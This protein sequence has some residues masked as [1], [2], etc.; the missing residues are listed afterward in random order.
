[1]PNSTRASNA[2]RR[3]LAEDLE[4]AA[5]R[6]QSK[7]AAQAAANVQ[8]AAN[9][10]N[11]V[12]LRL[13]ADIDPT[14]TGQR[15]TITPAIVEQQIDLL[16]NYTAGDAFLYRQT[17]RSTVSREMYLNSRLHRASAADLHRRGVAAGAAHHRAGGRG[18]DGRGTNRRRQA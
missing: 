3:S 4:V 18:F 17:A 11:E 14:P 10:W 7:R 16:V 13:I 12:R 9:N 2:W 5:Q 6:S 8:R 1:M 15:W